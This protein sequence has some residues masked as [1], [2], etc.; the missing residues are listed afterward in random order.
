MTVKFSVA[1]AN[2][3]NNAIET[4]IGTA[5]LLKIYTGVPPAT[6]ADA[7]TETLLCSITLPSNWL[8]DS[9]GALP[10]RKQNDSDWT[11]TGVGAG[12]VGHFRLWDSGG[13]VCH[14]QGTAGY[15]AR[16]IWVQPATISVGCSVKMPAGSFSLYFGVA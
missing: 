7:E 11:G 10:V 5:P 4:A 16:D 6:C 3:S 14:M 8:P 2:A 1:V 15:S 12:S 9:S 13:T